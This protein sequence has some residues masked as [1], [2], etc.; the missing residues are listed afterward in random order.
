MSE[1]V[2]L[3]IDQGSVHLEFTLQPGPL[4][5]Q[6]TIWDT[7]PKGKPRS[8]VVNHGEPVNYVVRFKV[9]A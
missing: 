8:T 5:N 3:V 4:H 7:D 6:V 1:P 2:L 9:N